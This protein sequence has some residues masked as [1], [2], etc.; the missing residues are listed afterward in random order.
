MKGQIKVR[1]NKCGW[2]G[3]EDELEL[4]GIAEVDGEEIPIVH[5]SRSS[6]HVTV[7]KL[8]EA[9]EFIDGCPN[10]LTDDYLMD[11]ETN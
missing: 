3:F 11:I 1:C 5:E 10:C 8:I 2:I 9:K 7:L 6:R 4:I